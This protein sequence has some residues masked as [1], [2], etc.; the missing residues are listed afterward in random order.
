MLKKVATQLSPRV[1]A[2]RR[3]GALGGKARAEKYKGTA[4]LAKWGRKGGN[5]T[6]ALYGSEFFVHANSRTKTVGRYRTPRKA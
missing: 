2:A 6:L 1:V 3:N 5:M 4:K